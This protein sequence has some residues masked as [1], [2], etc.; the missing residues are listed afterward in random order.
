MEEEISKIIALQKSFIKINEEENSN[1]ID[2]LI[3]SSYVD[4]KKNIDRLLFIIQASLL[5]KPHLHQYYIN[6]LVKLIPN[7]KKHYNFDE[8][9]SPQI[10]YL[11]FQNRYIATIMIQNHLFTI[12]QYREQYGNFNLVD[13]NQK[14]NPLYTSIK[15]DD[16]D[17]FL[18]IVSKTNL[19]INKK[20]EYNQY[21][22]FCS[23]A[24][25]PWDMTYII[26]L[27]AYCGSITIFKYLYA[28]QANLNLKKLLYY[29]FAGGNYDIIHYVEDN[30]F[31]YDK[32]ELAIAA[33]EHHSNE[34]IN[35]LIDNYN[36]SIND[37][38]CVA[39]CVKSNN[40]EILQQIFEDKIDENSPLTICG[41]NCSARFANLDSLKFFVD[42]KK[43]DLTNKIYYYGS[44]LF[45]AAVRNYDI[46]MIK[47]IHDKIG[48]NINCC[49][50]S[51]E[52]QKKKI[53]YGPSLCNCYK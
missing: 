27:A 32:S 21:D 1:L 24:N 5:A 41:I 9:L 52:F 25:T 45:K 44:S 42:I 23:Q 28:N 37:N 39:S 3:S 35:Y 14:E 46:E 53:N 8:L 19:D 47:Y 22:F 36:I 48:K 15:L 10:R 2:D 4:E 17:T 26:E 49:D 31:E 30:D 20:L 50:D 34:F 18:S 13:T 33:I 7:L 43:V 29:A 38:K 16:F 12:E 11:F 40:L 51:G 6:C